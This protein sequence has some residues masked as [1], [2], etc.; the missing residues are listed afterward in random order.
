[1]TII[2]LIFADTLPKTTAAHHAE[3]LALRLA[4]AVKTISVIFSPV[5]TVL[6][7]IATGFGKLIGA[8]TVGGSLYSE[9]EIRTMI[10]IGA[11]MER[12]KKPPP[13]YC[14]K[15]SISPTVPPAR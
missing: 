13:N 7:W 6:S 4:R 9:E 12:W 5:V 2:L 15:Y 11:R 14:I 1:M 3:M 8:H 10:N